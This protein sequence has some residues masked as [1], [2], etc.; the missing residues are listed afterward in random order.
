MVVHQLAIDGPMSGY[1]LKRWGLTPE[2]AADEAARR[3]S[4]IVPL[5]DEALQLAK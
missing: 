1:F 4:W 5:V 3:L 2:E